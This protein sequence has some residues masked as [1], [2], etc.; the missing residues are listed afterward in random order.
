MG[1]EE[2]KTKKKIIKKSH[3]SNTKVTITFFLFLSGVI[4]TD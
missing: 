3:E 2:E 4:G 1:F